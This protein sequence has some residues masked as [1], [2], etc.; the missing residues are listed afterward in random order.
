VKIVANSL[1]GE[2]LMIDCSC[3]V[4][5]CWKHCCKVLMESTKRIIAPNPVY[6]KRNAKRHR[7]ENLKQQDI[8]V[9]VVL[10][11][12]SESDSGSAYVKDNFDQEILGIYFTLTKSN[13]CAKEH[14]AELKCNDDDEEEKDD[15]DEDVNLFLRSIRKIHI[16][17]F[18]S[19][20]DRL[21]M[22]LSHSINENT[23]LFIMF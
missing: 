6:I 22:L 4:R 14:V 2:I 17:K 8:C 3:P 9:H 1:T 12:K 16:V 13:K 10:T 7:I 15:D 20:K 11:C 18:G 21:K 19:K 5:G 23:S